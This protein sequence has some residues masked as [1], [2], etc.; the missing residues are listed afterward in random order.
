MRLFFALWPPAPVAKALS[1]VAEC[2]A[3]R[4]GGRATRT[5]TIHMTLAFLGEQPREKLPEILAA[6]RAVR[7]AP[8]D[9]SLDRLGGWR[10]HRL[11]WAGCQ[12]APVALQD[13]AA[14]LHARLRNSAA[15][16]GAGDAERAK[17]HFFPHVTLVRKLPAQAFPL[18][19][20]ACRP[21]SWPCRSFVLVESRLSAAGAEYR[22]MDTF[23]CCD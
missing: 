20:P 23:D 21:L 13:L 14:G 11:L 2:C 18:A 15:A 3:Q 8:F 1:D 17:W 10:H 5:A 6:A 7:M 12:S 16:F 4:L 9:L 22:L 19:L